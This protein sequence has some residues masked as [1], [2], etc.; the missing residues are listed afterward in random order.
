MKGAQKANPPMAMQD[1]L[2]KVHLC[3][4]C[5]AK[6]QKYMKT[7]KG[8]DCSCGQTGGGC[9]CDQSGGAKRRTKKMN[10]AKMKGAKMKGA[11][12]NGAKMKGGGDDDDKEEPFIDFT[13]K[14]GLEELGEDTDGTKL[15]IQRVEEI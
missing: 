13:N 3:K 15:D 2:S 1:M 11:K 6:M 14:N 9:G 5:T 8:G 7:Q 4:K 10:G 12:M